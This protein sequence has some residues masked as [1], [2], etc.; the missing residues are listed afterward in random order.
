M[1]FGWGRWGARTP[2]L[3]SAAVIRLR[4]SRILGSYFTPRRG[5]AGRERLSDALSLCGRFRTNKRLGAFDDAA[6]ELTRQQPGR[7]CYVLSHAYY[8]IIMHHCYNY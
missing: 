3:F 1:P 7:Q 8:H 2:P 5:A 4:W 6:A